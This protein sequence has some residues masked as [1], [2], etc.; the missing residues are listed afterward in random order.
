MIESCCEREVPTRSEV[1]DAH[2]DGHRNMYAASFGRCTPSLAML[3]R[4]K[5]GKAQAWFSGGGITIVACVPLKWK[6]HEI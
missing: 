6:E 1:V 3:V 2:E 5:L 4:E